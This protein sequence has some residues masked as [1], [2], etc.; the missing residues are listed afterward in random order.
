MDNSLPLQLIFIWHRKT[1]NE[2]S[3]KDMDAFQESIKI[4]AEKND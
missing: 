2:A 3:K 4:N 1:E